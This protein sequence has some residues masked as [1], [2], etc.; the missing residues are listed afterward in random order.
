MSSSSSHDHLLSLTCDVLHAHSAVLVLPDGNENF[1]VAAAAC[2]TQ[3][4]P[5]AAE[6]TSGK[7]L[8][9][10]V[11]RNREPVIINDF[12]AETHFLGYYD[13]ESEHTITAF[14]GVP[15][16]EGGGALCVDSVGG[17]PFTKRDE[18]ILIRFARL[19]SGQNRLEHE[20]SGDDDVRRYFETFE[21]LQL[22]RTKSLPWHDYLGHFLAHMAQGTQ[23]DY[24]A[25]IMRPED[26]PTY[27]IEGESTPLLLSEGTE[28]NLPVDSLGLVSW[29]LRDGGRLPV[30]ADGL[31]GNTVMPL[32]GK[33]PQIPAFQSAICLPVTHN[34]AV[35]GV[36]VMA[37]LE[38]RVLPEQLR[39]FATMTAAEVGVHI[40]T[41]YLQHR[42]QGLLRKA[43]VTR[44]PHKD[45]T[46][47]APAK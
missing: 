47:D 9:G 7:G 22:L 46:T 1:R 27:T 24:V 21:Q 44:E 34:R 35:Y 6:I 32:F 31:E 25:L 17:Q 5:V 26:S 12:N 15:L 30:F 19:V 3:P 23:F 8:P 4:T 43:H 38:A 36:L 37:G 40:A 20:Q 18:S 16:P 41:L 2:A 42:V 39:S 14:M 33:L 28:V 10:L 13:E 11:L 45:K 29:V